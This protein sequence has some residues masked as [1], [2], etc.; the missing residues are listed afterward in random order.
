[1]LQLDQI[2]KQYEHNRWALRGVSLC[3]EAG[4]WGIVGPNGAGKTTLLRILATLLAPTQG[5]VNWKGQDSLRNP[6]VLRR[7]LGYLPQDFGVYP[8]LTAIEFLRYIGELK[9]LRGALLRRRVAAVLEAVHLEDDT[10]RRLSHFSGGMIRRIGIAQALLSEPRLLIF[11]EPTVGLDPAERVRFRE[12][13]ASL[14]GERIVI[15][16]THIVSDVEAMATNIVLLQHGRMCWSGTAAALLADAAGSIWSLT[17][18]AHDFEILRETYQISIAIRRGKQVEM[19][20]IA[21]DRPHP[22]AVSVEPTLEEA[23]LYF[24]NDASDTRSANVIV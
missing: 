7:E 8:Q 19:H 10:N 23:Y 18:D 5:C 2:G 4:V 15:L 17:L 13:I 21:P 9:G 12:L 22:E 24:V 11:D 3:M 1:M 20:L 16:S 6:Q 14:Q